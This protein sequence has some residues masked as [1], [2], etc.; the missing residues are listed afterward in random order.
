MFNKQ[1]LAVK[2]FKRG[3]LGEHPPGEDGY[4]S[5]AIIALF[6]WMST[7]LV[8]MGTTSPGEDGCHNIGVNILLTPER[9]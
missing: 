6:N 3:L 5:I 7:L 9:D 2:S 8:R 4:Q 1:A